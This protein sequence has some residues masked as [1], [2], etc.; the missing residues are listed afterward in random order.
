MPSSHAGQYVLTT[1]T[2]DLRIERTSIVSRASSGDKESWICAAALVV[3]AIV[4]TLGT[5]P[6]AAQVSTAGPNA[7]CLEAKLVSSVPLGQAAD[8]NTVASVL[9]SLTNFFVE[10]D[11]QTLTGRLTC[12]DPRPAFYNCGHTKQS[13]WGC[14]PDCFMERDGSQYV[15]ESLGKSFSVSGDST[16]I[17]QFLTDQVSITGELKGDTIKAISITKAPKKERPSSTRSETG[18]P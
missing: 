5:A 2:Q 16:R 3:A 14:K 13:V 18:T 11:T 7:S 9:P 17:R 6:L 4:A 10:T 1:R 15:L 12:A 8:E